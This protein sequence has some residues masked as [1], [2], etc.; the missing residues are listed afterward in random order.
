MVYHLRSGHSYGG[1][2]SAH[3]SF[4]SGFG[5]GVMPGRDPYVS[6]PPVTPRPSSPTA[7]GNQTSDEVGL[8]INA[9]VASVDAI[10]SELDKLTPTSE[11]ERG[12]TTVCNLLIAQVRELK[13]A[14]QNLHEDHVKINSRL[15]SHCDEALNVLTDHDISLVK[16]EQYTRRDTV[17]LLC[18]QRTDNE[19]TESL[20]KRIASTLSSSSV[21]V[22]PADL[23]VVHRNSKLDRTIKGKTVPPSITARF[24]S[25]N[26]KDEVIRKYKN[27]DHT[28]SK[29]R[30]CRVYNALSPHYDELRKNIVQFFRPDPSDPT[31]IKY[32]L[33]WV[34]Y[35]SPTAGLAIKLQSG[36]Y[37]RD[38]HVW[39]DFMRGFTH[40]VVAQQAAS[41]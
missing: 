16:M 22:K 41:V 28:N 5:H 18:V 11:F 33:K 17:T 39:D 7:T 2:R 32:K 25:I 4:S 10:K 6:G 3:S 38:V 23:S 37:F 20:T 26:L 40:K 1:S 8:K 36:E 31:V 12:L 14:Q 19:T 24:H 30:E 21:D 9:I 29:P 27:F 34:T 35:Q 13:V 15:N